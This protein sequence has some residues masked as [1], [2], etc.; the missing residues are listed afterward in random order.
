MQTCL[1][2]LEWVPEEEE[3][4]LMLS[5]KQMEAD[6]EELLANELVVHWGSAE[7]AHDQRW[8]WSEGPDFSLGLA[9]VQ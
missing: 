8:A 1:P 7:L 6:L 2:N 5:W 3:G 4:P 9:P